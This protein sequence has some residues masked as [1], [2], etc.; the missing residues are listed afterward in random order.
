[1]KE[2]RDWICQ[3]LLQS[4]LRKVANGYNYYKVRNKTLPAPFE[5]NVVSVSDKNWFYHIFEIGC[6]LDS[7]VTH[8]CVFYYLRKIGFYG[9]SAA[10]RFTTTDVYAMFVSQSRNKS[11]CNVDD[12]LIDYI[13]GYKII[14]AVPWSKVDHVMFPMHLEINN[15]G[16]W[17]LGR[18]SLDDMKLYIYNSIRTEDCDV[19]VTE[20]VKAY[21][22]ILPIFLALVNFSRSGVACN[23][24]IE[25]VMVDNL[26]QQNNSDCG[27]YVASF[28]E[29]FI[30][31]HEINKEKFD[32]TSFR[33]R[34]AY[35]LYDHGKMKQDNGY[36][37]DD[38][39]PGSAPD[40]V[41]ISLLNLR[42]KS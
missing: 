18:F 35:L 11:V 8:G 29:H 22:E 36:V 25:V 17:I 9:K 28:A 38:E 33:E 21:V 42:E 6:F 41:R 37:S 13:L 2:F 12:M 15:V 19:L 24:N 39:S 26:P 4:A 20:I 5:F 14:C 30:S 1:M 40:E 32:V 3:G 31:G 23:G 27:V 34:Y 10:V 16:H 7:S